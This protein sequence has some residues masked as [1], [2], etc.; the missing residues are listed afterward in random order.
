MKAP[1]GFVALIL[2]DQ[3][4]DGLPGLTGVWLPG[5]VGVVLPPGD[6]AELPEMPGDTAELPGG[7]VG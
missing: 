6:T 5:L 2:R 4:L 1:K 3:R 7:N